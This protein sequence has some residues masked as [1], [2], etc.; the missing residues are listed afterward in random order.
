MSDTKRISKKTQEQELIE[1][2][3][4]LIGSSEF[5]FVVP[6]EWSNE[7]DSIKRFSLYEDYTPVKTSGGTILN[8]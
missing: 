4:N 6:M 8:L 1:D 3:E 5:S 2:Y 7:G